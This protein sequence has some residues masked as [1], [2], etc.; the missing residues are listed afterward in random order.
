MKKTPLILISLLL[1][2]PFLSIITV[3]AGS[4]N[5]TLQF[6]HWANPSAREYGMGVSYIEVYDNSTGSFKLQEN[7]TYLKGGC[8]VN[9][10]S[11]IQL[12]IGYVA[13]HTL[14]VWDATDNSTGSNYLQFNITV[15][16]SNGTIIFT[17]QNGT[18]V[19]NR[20]LGNELTM[21]EHSII[22]NFET[23]YA[24]VYTVA[25]M[26]DYYEG[27]VTVT[28]PAGKDY[29]YVN[30]M[31]NT[32]WETALDDV[33]Q[34]QDGGSNKFLLDGGDTYGYAQDAISFTMPVNAWL[35][36]SI[37]DWVGGDS[38]LGSIQMHIAGAWVYHL[39]N[40]TGTGDYAVN[41]STHAG[42]PCLWIMYNLHDG[43]DG[44]SYYS[45][46]YFSLYLNDTITD[47]ARSAYGYYNDLSNNTWVDASPYCVVDDMGTSIRIED[48]EGGHLW[49]SAND[50]GISVV[51][52]EDF[53]YIEIYVDEGQP[54]VNWDSWGVRLWWVNGTSYN[55]WDGV[56]V[57]FGRYE[58]NALALCDS[59]NTTINRIDIICWGDDDLGDNL[60]FDYLNIYD[61]LAWYTQEVSIVLSG[62]IFEG[63]ITAGVSFIGLCL[64]PFGS[65]W[66]AMLIKH[67]KLDENT[68]IIPIAI[69]LL[70]FALLIGGMA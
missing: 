6:G 51:E 58:V 13:N 17:Q 46:D 22:L 8:E 67:K 20:Y 27:G 26:Y 53:P 31:S 23:E 57:F 48:D 19:S 65:F 36:V 40:W 54:D 39:V 21:F 28:L 18:Y 7:V 55:V 61:K 47:S 62:P 59:E 38:F 69:V 43:T 9:A 37:T 2:L 14:L 50:T 1:V 35:E 12:I 49:G 41:M 25:L 32:T 66:G 30:D 33:I 29:F 45:M 24:V 34:S 63:Y 4:I 15:T 3:H 10:T 70:G 44:V 68:W 42:K 5:P 56:V 52:L 11:S 16:H 60:G 64:I